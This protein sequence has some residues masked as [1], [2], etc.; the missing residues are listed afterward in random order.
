[1][2]RDGTAGL[3]EARSHHLGNLHQLLVARCSVSLHRVF[4]IGARHHAVVR[5]TVFRCRAV[6]VIVVVE[7]NP[8]VGTND[9]TLHAVMDVVHLVRTFHRPFHHHVVALRAG[10]CHHAADVA[11]SRQVGR[12]GVRSELLVVDS[13]SNA[14]IVEIAHRSILIIHKGSLRLLAVDRQVIDPHPSCFSALA[15]FHIPAEARTL[16]RVVPNNTNLLVAGQVLRQFDR[17]VECRICHC[18]LEEVVVVVLLRLPRQMDEVL[19]ILLFKNVWQEY[20]SIDVLLVVLDVGVRHLQVGVLARNIIHNGIVRG[21]LSLFITQHV[22]SAVRQAVNVLVSV[23]C[24]LLALPCHHVLLGPFVELHHHV[25]R[26]G[27]R[28]DENAVAIVHPRSRMLVCLLLQYEARNAHVSLQRNVVV[29]VKVSGRNRIRP[30]RR[31]D[32]ITDIATAASRL[33]V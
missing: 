1:M 32:N 10:G 17:Q 18:L 30:H 16:H 3:R 22:P 13:G 7:Q 20:H 2:S 14:I 26:T 33:G 23:L 25:H 11:A 28:F 15:L 12:E 4:I 29:N 6:N 24:L 31:A 8:F 19:G 27:V 21:R 9:A 5:E